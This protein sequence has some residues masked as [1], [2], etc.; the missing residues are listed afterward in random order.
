MKPVKIAF[1]DIDG[2]LIDMGRKRISEKM[3]ET[4]FRLKEN[5]IQI[6]IAT[7]RSPLSLPHFPDIEFDGF[8]TF[9]GSYC[10][11]RERTLYSRCIPVDDV[12]KIIRN[13]E[14]LG[15]PV[16]LAAKDRFAAN[17]KDDD[18]VEYFSFAKMEVEIADDFDDVAGREVFQIMAGCRIEERGA[19]LQ[20]AD[21][22]EI[23]AWWDRAVDIIPAGSGKGTGVAK[24]L[25]RCGFNR[26]EA[27]AFGDGNND[28]ELLQAVGRGV[29]MGNASTELKRIADDVCGHVAQDGIYHYCMEHGLIV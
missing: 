9:N 13:A 6:W 4:L 15:R 7:G 28:I 11:D 8:L 19:M 14:G 17:G 5:H 20:G 24:V 12:R 2:T 29:A 27:I 22:A 1:F 3:L 23:T 25:E 18:L 26:E 10:F 21:G 16:C